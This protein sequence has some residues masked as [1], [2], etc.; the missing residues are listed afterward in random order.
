MKAVKVICKGGKMTERRVSKIELTH[1]KNTAA[2]E[3][4]RARVEAHVDM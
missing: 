2:Y 4:K 1:F 3:R